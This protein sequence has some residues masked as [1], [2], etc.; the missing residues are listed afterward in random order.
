MS[1]QEINFNIAM[2]IRNN[3]YDH[4]G[5]ILQCMNIR[6]TDSIPTAGVNYD[7]K[8]KKFN[9]FYNP[10][11][12]ASLKPLEQQ[13]V[14]IHEIDHILHG[15]VFMNIK[16]E[17]MKK[18][19]MAM[20]L[21]INQGNK[22]IPDMA[23]KVE[24][25][26]HKDGTLFELNKPSEFYYHSLL[27]EGAEMKMKGQ[28]GDQE[29]QGDNQEQ[30]GGQG[31]N[32]GQ[33]EQ[34]VKVSDYLKNNE[35][36]T[37]D[38]H[39]W[40]SL[41]ETE[42]KEVLDALK[43]VI[44]TARKKTEDYGKGASVLD[45]KLNEINKDIDS[46]D[47]KSVIRTA[48]KRS[49]PATNFARSFSRPNRRLGVKSAGKVIEIL[50]KITFL[51]DTSGSIDIEQANEFLTVVDEFMGIVSKAEL[52]FFNTETYKVMP[53]K[54]GTRIK[55]ADIESGGTCLTHSL[56]KI[57]KERADLVVVLTDGYFAMPEVN[58][59]K[60]PKTVFILNESGDK[61]HPMATKCKTYFYKNRGT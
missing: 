23:L 16:K 42:K 14:L 13:A 40:E 37:F 31:Q 61:N 38:S 45:A 9:L 46:L 60:L 59:K 24:N 52:H 27:S 32:Q 50:P 8:S 54:K 18:W 39:D 10:K 44:K 48:L 26:R 49:L 4:V 58:V 28:S 19:N 15:H 25:F 2:L 22:H 43:D 12:M 53:L 35:Q 41:S 47:Y 6:P 1:L 34:W 51:L 21:V 7:Q 17:D 20:D 56:N 36:A 29:Q 57:L 5:Y 33:G 3:D 11:F 55:E 30:S